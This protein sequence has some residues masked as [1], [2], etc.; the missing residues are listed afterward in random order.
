MTSA[1]LLTALRRAQDNMPGHL[2]FIGPLLIEG[3]DPPDASTPF[4]CLFY[5]DAD[6]NLYTNQNKSGDLD[7][8][9]LVLPGAFLEAEEKLLKV[10]V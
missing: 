7:D 3:A 9:L 10:T 1:T 8:W 2:P 6:G 4:N 5:A